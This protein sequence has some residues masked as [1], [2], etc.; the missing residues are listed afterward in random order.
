MTS[1]SRFLAC[2]IV[3][4]IPAIAPGQAVPSPANKP[5]RASI[6]D[7]KAD[8]REQVK[9]ASALAKR[10]AKRV[11]VMF[12]GDWCG[13]CHKLHALFASNAEIKKMLSTEYV[14][15]MVDTEAPNA[16][17]LLAECVGDLP[18]VGFPFL[19]VL[20]RQ[21]QIVTRQRTDPLEEG[22]HHDP[23]KVKEF[24]GKWV[25]PKA[26]A[27]K[28]LEDGLA[29]ARSEDKALFLHF[30]AP[31]CGW[32]HQLD[33]FLARADMSEILGKEFVDLK[34]DTERM[35]GGDAILAKYNAEKAGGIPWFVFLDTSGKPIVNSE[36]PKGNIGYPASPEEIDHFIHMIKKS[37]RKLDASQI[38]TIEDVLKLEAKKL[39][40]A[41]T[42]PAK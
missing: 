26:D 8:A 22:D 39:E 4:S 31:W 41:R 3:L 29:K 24:L 42:S 38:K 19:A 30:G 27:V 21:G 28:V 25:A 40:Q 36:G 5:V 33:A 7:A 10:D 12:G 35:I 15:V 6:Y 23:V 34:I 11:L 20:D 16:R 9:V 14:L 13:W 32:C 37:A 2:A 18:P 1:L 17:A